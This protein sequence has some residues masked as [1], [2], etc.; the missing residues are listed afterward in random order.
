MSW[1]DQIEHMIEKEKKSKNVNI[2]NKK[3]K[4]SNNK[5][6]KINFLKSVRF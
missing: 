2:F 5:K 4:I 3:F 6:S 1:I